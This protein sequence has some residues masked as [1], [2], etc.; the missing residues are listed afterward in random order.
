MLPAVQ[1]VTGALTGQTSGCRM[2]LNAFSA[3]IL[4]PLALDGG[5][6]VV[7]GSTG[8]R[9][10]MEGGH[11]YYS[12]SF[13]AMTYTLDAIPA[14]FFAT[15]D[16]WVEAPG[17]RDVAAFQA[18]LRIPPIL[19]WT[20]RASVSTVSRANDLT[21]TW[22]RAGYTDREWVQASVH[23]G[24]AAADCQTP[25]T[26]GSITIPASLISQLPDSG[27]AVARVQLMLTPANRDL[28]LY[29]VPLI[30][31]GTFPGVSS[32]GFLDTASVE[33]R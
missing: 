16:W 2:S 14:S 21:L 15:G 12:K 3:G 33:L 32:F 27:A 18:S 5:V 28:A 6:P 1:A 7:V 26:A 8:V 9:L 30:G 17:G 24:S 31:G 23:V 19:R 29:T 13:S 22:D 25:A 11:G 20:N 10:P 4:H